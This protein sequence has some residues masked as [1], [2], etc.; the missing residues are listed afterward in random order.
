MHIDTAERGSERIAG[1]RIRPNAA[2]AIRSGFPSSQCL[3][4]FRI[5]HLERLQKRNPRSL[6][7]EVSPVMALG[8]ARALSDDR[9]ES[10]R[11]QPELSDLSKASSE[12]TAKSGVPMNTMRMV[13]L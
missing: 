7:R 1:G 12:A 13:S 9:V 11:P 10:Q 5:L 8:F 4:K 2:T 6:G 3:E